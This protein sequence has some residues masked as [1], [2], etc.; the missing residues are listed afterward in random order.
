MRLH[1]LLDRV[2]VR[3]REGRVDELACIRVPRVDGQLGAEHRDVADLVDAR[4]VEPRVDALRE[5]VER[6][7]DEVDVAR[8]LAVAEE[9]ALDALAAGHQRELGRRH[10]R[11]AIVVRVQADDHA[12]APRDPAAERLDQVGVEVRRGELDRRGQVE[13]QLSL[14]RRLEHVHDR[15]AHLERVVG[16][17]GGEALR[18]VLEAHVAS[19][20][21]IGELANALG[22]AHGDLANAVAVEPEDDAALRGRG[23]V[24]E[25]DDRPRDA[26]E[27]LEGA[28]DQVVARL[29][30]D[31]DRDVVGDQALV[32]EHAHEV[33]VG[34]RGRREADLDLLEAD[35][36]QQLEHAPFALDV[37]GVDERLVAV[38]QVD[39][40]PAR[41]ARDAL[42]GPGAVGQLDARV[43]A[44]LVMR[45]RHGLEASGRRGVDRA[46]PVAVATDAT[47]DYVHDCSPRRGGGGRQA[48]CAGTRRASRDDHSER[49]RRSQRRASHAGMLGLMYARSATQRIIGCQGS[50]GSRGVAGT[51]L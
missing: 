12:L 37:H 5:Q 6:Q 24:V 26:F 39:R 29:R 28:L 49:E 11:A 36:A 15:L 38:A 51:A 31:D 21:R 13:H 19:G 25:V 40:D 33:E 43:G 41:C 30:Q 17:G 27:A 23:R 32:D 4:E 42:V 48:G 10:G 1:A 18:R 46:R 44:V 9:G 2:L 14:G 8:A 3:A 16:L 35:G 50:P 7:R 34:L 45:H 22:A 47:D 20:A